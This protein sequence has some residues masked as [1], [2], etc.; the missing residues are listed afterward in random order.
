MPDAAVVRRRRRWPWVVAAVLV[1]A[2][3][4][5]GPLLAPVVAQM[6]A[7]QLA[8]AIDGQAEVAGAGGGWFFDAQLTGI[9]AEAPL[10]T[11][12]RLH[13]R[14]LAATYGL[15]LFGGDP[16]ALRSLTLDGIDATLDLRGG[17]GGVIPPLLE[18]LPSPLPQA[19]L[20][21][22]VLLLTR[23]REVRLSQVA[24]HT[25]G[26]RVTL[27]A[28]V[29]VADS[30]MLQVSAAFTR[31][32]AD[33]LRLERAVVL[34]EA[35]VETLELVLGR[36]RQ[37]LTGSLLLGGGRCVLHADPTNARLVAE[38]L[39]L[40]AVPPSLAALLP[41]D[42]GALRG[43]LAG[44]ATA[45]HGADG[46][47]IAGTLSAR[48]LLI[49]GLG[50]FAL[51]GQ[52]QLGTGVARLPRLTVV[53]PGDGKV[54]VDGLE[55]ALAGRRPHAGAIHAVI[56]DVR[57]WL[58]ADISLPPTP[59]ALDA[60]LRV[61]GDTFAIR[62]AR[63]TGGGVALD[64]RGSLV[65][66]P[67]RIEAADVTARVDLAAIAGLIPA[68]PNLAGDLRARVTGTLPFT[69]DPTRLLAAAYEVQVR[70]E[71]LTLSSLAL[72]Q[73]RIDVRSGD[74]VLHLTQG[75]V[76]VAGI[77]VSVTGEARWSADGWQGALTSLVLALPG[78]QVTA[79]EPC[80]FL[81]AGDGWSVGPLRLTSAA[82]ALTLE[83]RQRDGSGLLALA[84][85]RID[86]ARLGFPELSGTA[87][88]VIDLSGAW[89]APQLDLRLTSRD[90][91]ID[92]WQA[93]VDVHLTQD[94]H[95]IVVQRGRIH[96]GDDGSVQLAGTLPFVL[97]VAGLGV[98]PDDGHPATITLDLP[99]LDRWVPERVDAG[100]LSLAV[101]LGT[102]SDPAAVQAT[103]RYSGVR[104][105]RASRPTLRPGLP[106][107]QLDG[108]FVLTADGNGIALTLAGSAD[109]RP[110]LSGAL[111]S[112]G[113]WD[114][115][116]LWH[117][118]HTRPLAGRLLLDGADLGRFASAIP[119][120]LHLAG[121]ARGEL[122]VGGSLGQPGFTGDLTLSGVEAKIT[123]MVPTLSDGRA[124][125]EL[126]EGR[127]RL[128]D[129]VADLG[130][131]PLRLGGEVELGATPRLALTL[132]G[133]NVLLVQRHDARLRADLDLTLAGPVSALQLSGR[134][135]VTNALFTPDLGLFS[136]G[137]GTRGDGRVVPF[138]FNDPPL[139]T[140]RFDVAVSS[141][142]GDGRDGVRLVT[143]LVRADCDLDLRLRGS[144]SAPELAGRVTMRKGVVFLP[145][146]TLRL[147]TGELLF[148]EGDPFHPR[149]NAVATAQVRR[150]TIALQ[151]DGPLSD[152]Q[153]R[154]GGDG[155]DERDALLLLTTGS[156]SA[157]LSGE[158]GQRSALGRLGTWLGAEAWDLIDGEADPDAGPG[159]LE[160]VTLQ[161]GRQVSDAGNDTIEAEVELTDPE[162][163]P[164]V[165]IYGE[166]DRYDDYNAGVILRFRWGGER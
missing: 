54:T 64:V 50:P 147:S 51:D 40:A 35:T 44:E 29:Q 76:A 26:E 106:P 109:G 161:F 157:E 71:D 112:A 9:R 48:D 164:G 141:A 98:V 93:L 96:A 159:V 165:L 57:R 166:R 90:L 162:L 75:D 92:T 27:A 73:V 94:Q 43:T 154:A 5:R 119:G 103:L 36:A 21:G 56:A 33:T 31:P 2:F 12:R 145:F 10:G 22:E 142:H 30:D 101:A 116:A 18:L 99:A 125:L 127:V 65:T 110:V 121:Q 46:W 102:A 72:G 150:W 151:V 15:G 59:V 131:A 132:T 124:R 16:G 38:G 34:G 77:P 86:L 83:A 11:V 137:G 66:A 60:D 87:G 113:A 68:A 70:G 3:L 138:E 79:A 62:T 104:P 14:S 20:T 149:L 133:S 91:R 107:A 74:G 23:D 123:E 32:T 24:L 139:S 97:G 80:P 115:V 148:P 4:L 47:Q 88:A 128:H 19:S 6:V 130:G 53:G 111:Q 85:P 155:L 42:L 45:V 153:V 118:G 136:G 17:G 152:P 81:I 134:T 8:Q 63:L 13:V 95:G 144:G 67:W 140:L 55:L 37:Q 120:L 84:A 158:E 69:S 82:G 156:T 135:V 146:S 61:E 105:V 28:Q 89:T 126:R 122:A 117:H 163:V 7:K 108:E 58:P 100:A 129:A 78:V 39:D 52:W 114:P 49:A 160:R 1:V 41:P 25:S 143:D